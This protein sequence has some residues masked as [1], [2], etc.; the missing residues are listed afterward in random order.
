[1][2]D[3]ADYVYF[4]DRDNSIYKFRGSDGTRMWIYNHGHEGDHHASPVIGE[5]GSVY[6]AFSQNSDGNGSILAVRDTGGAII[7]APAVLPDTYIKWKFAVGQFATTSSP[8]L[9]KDEDGAPMLIQGFADAKVRAIRD[10]GTNASV[11]WATAVGVGTIA[12]SPVLSADGRTLYIGGWG[13][14]YALDAM[15]GHLKW[16]FPTSPANVDSTA[17]LNAG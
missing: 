14:L 5:D 3:H 16:T 1:A 13:G 6:F 2:V 15:D 10:N 9:T 11:K 7:P 8:V 17:A 4:G 12:A